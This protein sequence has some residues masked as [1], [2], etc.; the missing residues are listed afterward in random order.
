MVWLDQPTTDYNFK[1]L[2]N[3]VV[4][5]VVRGSNNIFEKLQDV[6][7]QNHRLTIVVIISNLPL[8]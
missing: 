1:H 8:T 5:V 7:C 3:R 4:E 6:T 2:A